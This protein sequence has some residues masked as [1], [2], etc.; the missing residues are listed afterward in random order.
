MAYQDQ[1]DAFANYPF[2]RPIETDEFDLGA[3]L[4]IAAGAVGAG[5]LAGSTFAISA[6]HMPETIEVA[7]LGVPLL[8][9]AVLAGLGAR[10]AER[11]GRR[12]V[13]TA[14]G[15]HAVALIVWPAMILLA[16]AY[17]MWAL[18]AACVAVGGFLAM[19]RLST[20]LML[21]FAGHGFLFA[22]AVAFFQITQQLG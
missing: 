12:G 20:R 1:H 16:P 11:S 4:G 5:A 19:S 13:A 14:L 9:A 10:I 6:G 7:L 21:G 8:A 3:R 22:A 17:A 2:G 18:A 15:L